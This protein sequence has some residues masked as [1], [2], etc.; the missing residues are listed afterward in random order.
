MSQRVSVRWGAATGPVWLC[1]VAER[2]MLRPSFVPPPR[3]RELRDLTRYRSD[4]VSARTAE[5]QRVEKL[6]EDAQIKLSVVASDLF[7]V[8]GRAMMSA[9]VH[10]ERDPKVL[11]GMALR[12]LKAKTGRLEEAFEGRFSDHHAFLLRT[13]LGRIDG[14]S[15]DIAV[16]DGRIEEQVSPFADVLE[17]LDE[18][19][20][21]GPTIARVIVAEVGLDMT[22]F[23]TAAHLASWARFAPVVKESAGRTK[24]TG[25]TGKG[26]RY[27]ARVLGEAV[28]GAARTDTFLGQRY[29]RLV[30]RRGKGRA[31]VA[32][33]R[34]ILTVVWH[35]LSEP[36]T[37]FH[38]LGPD[39][40]E[41]HVNQGRKV[42]N[43]IRE[44]QQLGYHVTLEPTAA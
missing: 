23:P 18:I 26:N 13:M 44:L 9:L 15:A 28:V 37:H 20:G 1:R 12:R 27:L 8:S 16:V 17:R 35:I 31:L 21:V 25:G 19:P 36:D 11:A 29:R 42:R 3:I 14:L 32:V 6:L 4:L 34:S 2:D 22:R 43:H 10:G 24:G 39:Y 30:R 33:G 41:L 38:D 7:G 5:K 40:H